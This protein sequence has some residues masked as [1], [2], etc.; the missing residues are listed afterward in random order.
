MTEKPKPGI[1]F[2]GKDNGN[3]KVGIHWSTFTTY[4]SQFVTEDGWLNYEIVKLNSPTEKGYTHRFIVDK[5]Q[6]KAETK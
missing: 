6:K 3:I 2:R 4:F 5:P 1:N